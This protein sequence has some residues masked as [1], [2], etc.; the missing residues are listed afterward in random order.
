MKVSVVT[1]PD[2]ASDP[3]HPDHDRWVKDKTLKMEIDHAQAI[4][5]SARDAEV[6]NLRLLNRAERLAND[7]PQKL[8]KK[9][10]PGTNVG[11]AARKK[12]RGVFVREASP[13]VSGAKL[14][15]CGRCGTCLRC[16]REKR[17]F[18]MSLKAREGDRRF[19]LILWQLAMYA[20]QA[21]DGTG[22]FAGV[23]PRD[24]NRMVISKLEEVCDGT[25][26]FMGQW[27]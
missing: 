3:A 15:P 12:K 21:Q 10:P 23:N 4:G 5:L 20:Q 9:Q 7:K 22:R 24:A 17:V 1:I 25:I 27:R 11:S 8:T 18:A 26:P 16:K 14:S 6:E 13:L 19:A 2:A